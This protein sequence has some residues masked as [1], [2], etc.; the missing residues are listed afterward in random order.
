MKKINTINY[1]QYKTLYHTTLNQK[2]DTNKPLINILD[3]EYK[4]LKQLNIDIN[5]EIYPVKDTLQSITN[6]K[7]SD[8]KIYPNVDVDN[9]LHWTINFRDFILNELKD[10]LTYSLAIQGYSKKD[11]TILTYGPHILVTNKINIDRHI[12]KIE[13][14]MDSSILNMESDSIDP[15]DLMIKF[16]Y[17]IISII[18]KVHQEV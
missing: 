17:R 6:F 7:F 11:N 13:G 4:I 5:N 1:I 3:Y 8:Y 10:G 9:N 14:Q 2:S 12:V 16:K 18:K 15:E